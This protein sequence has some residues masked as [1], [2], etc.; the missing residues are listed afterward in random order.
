MENN[1]VR[2]EIARVAALEGCPFLIPPLKGAGRVSIYFWILTIRK[3]AI[4]RDMRQI[5]FRVIRS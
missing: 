1:S 4:I 3:Q 2:T 5:C